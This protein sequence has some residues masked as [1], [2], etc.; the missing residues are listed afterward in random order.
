[1]AVR[2]PTVEQ[3]LAEWSIGTSKADL[4]RWQEGTKRYEAGSLDDQTEMMESSVLMCSALTHYVN[5]E[6]IL[7]G[8]S[9]ESATVQVV[10]TVWK[11]LVASLSRANGYDLPVESERHLR[12]ALAAASKGSHQS[13]D[14]GGSGLMGEIFDDGTYRILLGN[15]LLNSPAIEE[16]GHVTLTDWFGSQQPPPKPT[17]TIKGTGVDK[18]TAREPHGSLSWGTLSERARQAK[19]HLNP[20]VL[21][22]GIESL[23][24]ALTAANLAKVDKK[25]GKLKAKKIGIAKAA[26]RPTKT[27]RRA[28]DG[29]LPTVRTMADGHDSGEPH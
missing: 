13:V 17:L 26:L 5:G 7:T 22:Y 1:M 21:H 10:Q 20:A 24:G 2:E 14:L 28:I 4:E 29:A 3:I 18:G 16:G 15:A 11:V 9:D 12:L 23:T 27:V 25:T 6:L 19:D 8:S